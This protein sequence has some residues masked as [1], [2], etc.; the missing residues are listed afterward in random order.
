MRWNCSEKRRE[1]FSSSLR[2]KNNRAPCI[3]LK[4]TVET[5]RRRAS[6]SCG[7]RHA[8]FTFA[9]LLSV[10]STVCL[11]SVQLLS[12]TARR[13]QSSATTLYRT[14]DVQER[15]RRRRHPLIQLAMQR[16][17]RRSTSIDTRIEDG[18]ELVNQIQAMKRE[19]LR[20]LKE[21]NFD[22][23][24]NTIKMMLKALEKAGDTG[25]AHISV[26]TIVDESIQA[27]TNLAFA[28]PH[29]GKATRER[30]SRGLTA[31]RL[32]LSSAA[33]LAPPFD[34]M[35]RSTFVNALKA[36]T[37]IVTNDNTKDVL[38]GKSYKPLDAAFRILQRL[39]TGRGVRNVSADQSVELSERDFN[40]VLN[41]VSHVGRMD[42]AH[43][44]VALQE[45][46]PHAPP[47]SPVAYS[48]MLKG[49]GRL[50]DVQNV[51]MILSHAGMNDVQPDTI[52]LNSVI[53]AFVNCNDLETAQDIFHYMKDPHYEG[54]V[55]SKFSSLLVADSRPT[56]NRRT[57]NTILKGLAK[58]GEKDAAMELSREMKAT[59]LWDNVTTNTLVSAAV[60]ASDF[61]LAESILAN[62]TAILEPGDK[63]RRHPNVEAYTELLDGYAKTSQLDRALG[64]LQLMR[65]RGV[66][67]NEYTY[68]CMIG[69]LA[70]AKKVEQAQ[71]MLQFMQTKDIKP[72]TLTYNALISGLV[73][74]TDEANDSET[75]GSDPLT[76]YV[77]E[78]IK[79]VP[80]MLRNGVR[81]NS[82]TISVLVD[83]LGR[84][85]HPRLAEAKA[86]VTKLRNDGII[87]NDDL[88]VT[89]ALIRTCGAGKDMI[90]ALENF[91]Q[92]KKP[93]IIAV[94]AF[95]DAC[96]RCEKEKVAFETF[97]HFFS[98]RSGG[99]LTPDVITY[100]VLIAA[101]LKKGTPQA[102]QRTIVL[103]NEMRKRRDIM[104][105][106]ALVDM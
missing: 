86:L 83:G 80:Q 78:A 14:K 29:R 48:I 38:P 56:P 98:N 82:I 4:E 84:C 33:L 39:V 27:F 55:L 74:D 66:D 93:D 105:D 1:F 43:K 72:R 49:Y 20:L 58:K 42:M 64:V 96:C 47:L 45:R 90:G 85:E 102:M 79:V 35:P 21:K 76:H 50:R 17:A 31:I 19:T 7:W 3:M 5:M 88:K 22:G 32:Q 61:D 53:D 75:F 99:K 69:G 15:T 24:L 106:K 25:G 68:T 59:E 101:L 67:P 18:S 34:T 41:A 103:Y 52:M 104:P 16:D 9:I 12:A 8:L 44:I 65:Q 36:L 62:H 94:N 40:M 2:Q 60:R 57:Y 100:S 26:S 71:K 46:T 95:L 73:A 91:R 6:L 97:N 37:G 13:A 11:S 23:A 77:S 81:P 28:Q 87:A 54:R 30:I 92:M 70:R 10:S 51:K 89:T 63:R